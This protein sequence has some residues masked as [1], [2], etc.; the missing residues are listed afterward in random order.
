MKCGL[1]E[2]PMRKLRI[3]KGK[4]DIVFCCESCADTYA[5]LEEECRGGKK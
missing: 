3:G 4:N 2:E 5:K 1:C